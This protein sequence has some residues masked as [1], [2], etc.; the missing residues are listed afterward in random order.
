MI[1]KGTYIG[2][3]G[4]SFARK[5]VLEMPYLLRG[6]NTSELDPKQGQTRVKDLDDYILEKALFR[7]RC[8]LRQGQ[9]SQP[10]SRCARLLH[11]KEACEHQLLPNV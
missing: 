3:K 4:M 11:V 2:W 8:V 10:A 6:M 9:L 7:L 5:I 1:A